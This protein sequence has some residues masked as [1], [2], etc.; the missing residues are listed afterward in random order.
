MNNGKNASL[1]LSS[2]KRLMQHFRKH[3]PRSPFFHLWSINTSLHTAQ[4]QTCTPRK[5][6]IQ[7][8]TTEALL[9]FLCA[10]KMDS[11]CIPGVNQMVI[12]PNELKP[13]GIWPRDAR[14]HTQARCTC[15]S[16]MHVTHPHTGLWGHAFY[17]ACVSICFTHKHSTVN[18]ERGCQTH[19]C[20]RLS[21]LS[22][23]L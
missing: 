14:N 16:H 7:F 18:T 23:F 4:R 5:T 3:V 21:F 17:S 22:Q 15:G 6:K 8:S 13:A 19:N 2:Q 12:K 11:V 10:D 9:I 1:P 20:A